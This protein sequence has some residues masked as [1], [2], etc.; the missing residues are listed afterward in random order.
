MTSTTSQIHYK[1][2]SEHK[3]H[4]YDMFTFQKQLYGYS[5]VFLTIL[6]QGYSF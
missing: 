3:V 5:S 4:S 2:H 1:E 6:H